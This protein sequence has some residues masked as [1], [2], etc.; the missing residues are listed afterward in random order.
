MRRISGLVSLLF[1]AG[2]ATAP[3]PAKA[4]EAPPPLE[5]AAPVAPTPRKEEPVAK[6]EPAKVPEPPAECRAYVER[7]GDKCVP[8]DARESVATALAE[9]DTGKRDALLVCVEKNPAFRPGFIRA[10]RADLGPE[11]CADAL[12]EPELALHSGLSVESEHALH[13][14]ALAAKLSRLVP[15][16]PKLA[17]PI[18]KPRFLHYF[19]AELKPWVVS[20]S[21]AIEQLSNQ[22]ARL[23]G[24]GKAIAAIGAGTADLRFVDRVREVPL[25]DEMKNV[26]E[27]NDAYY[28]A[29]DEA[30]EPRKQRGRDAVLVGLRLFSQ[31]GVIN[32]ARIARARALL[33]KLYSGSRVDALDKLLFPPFPAAKPMKLNERLALSLPSFYAASVLADADPSD[34]ELLRAL[35]ERG[36]PPALR[37]KLDQATLPARTQ[38]LYARGLVESGKVYFRAAEFRRV[39]ELLGPKPADEEAALLFGVSHVLASGPADITEV[40]FKGAQFASFGSSADL[41]AITK[42]KGRFAG[43]AAFDG[44]YLLELAP[45]RD[46]PK[47]WEDLTLRYRSAAKLLTA[48]GPKLAAAE[49][50]KAAASTAKALNAKP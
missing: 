25:P 32:D 29:L 9:K 19:E 16:P 49:Y 35:I 39:T 8:G 15:E 7:V 12:V 13:G 37:Q 5:D 45:R 3:P 6:P 4:P 20:Q 24:Y 44:A 40:M 28:A 43:E 48:P 30:L 34:P 1:A 22:G 47:F 31:L 2:C 38:R 21:A 50:E 11:G 33:A 42:A 17:P 27:V 26:K 14:L 36:I 46:D 23:T 18:D 41:D 10:L